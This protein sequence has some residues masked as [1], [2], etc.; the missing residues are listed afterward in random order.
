MSTSCING[1]KVLMMICIISV[2]LLLHNNR[3]AFESAD[4]V[5]ELN[6]QNW[7]EAV[8]KSDILFCVFYAPWCPHCTKLEVPL[9][10][11]AKYYTHDSRIKITK[12]DADKYKDFGKSKGVQ[13][14]PTIKLYKKSKEYSW[15]G[16]RTIDGFKQ[17]INSH[18]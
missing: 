10:H 6:P 13:G 15:D 14:F 16:P 9:T 12:L 8:H 17:F 11:L 1:S 5:R 7:R 18:L 4:Y 2:I 3:E